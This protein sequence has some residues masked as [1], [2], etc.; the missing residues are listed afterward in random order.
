M[1]AGV[2]LKPGTA[3]SAAQDVLQLVDVVLILTVEPGF[4][5]QAFMPAPLDKIRALRAQY[6]TLD[7]EVDGGITG[8]AGGERERGR[9]GERRER[10]ERRRRSGCECI[11]WVCFFWVLWRERT[12]FC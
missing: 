1:R 10:R 4:G 6:P 12:L 7:I 5:G 11:M 8:S 2:A 9:E 3:L